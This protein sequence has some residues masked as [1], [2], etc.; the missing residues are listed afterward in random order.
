M[1]R[2]N[3]VGSTSKDIFCLEGVNLFKY[4]WINT[5]NCAVVLNPKTKKPH[6]FSIYEINL[7][8]NQTITFIA[9]KFSNDEWSFFV[10]E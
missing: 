1:I 7:H 2:Y 8:N 9:G 6:T 10:Q 5:G 4:S 3:Y